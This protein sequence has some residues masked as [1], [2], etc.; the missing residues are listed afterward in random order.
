MTSTSASFGM[1]NVV[2]RT[3]REVGKFG[4]RSL[5]LPFGKKCAVRREV[6]LKA[7]PFLELGD[8]RI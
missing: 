3:A 1:L 6:A 8:G 2:P 4:L 7:K 5:Y